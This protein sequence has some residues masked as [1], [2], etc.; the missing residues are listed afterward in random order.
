M[1]SGLQ[2]NFRAVLKEKGLRKGGTADNTGKHEIGISNNLKFPL[3]EFDVSVNQIRFV[4]HLE[5]SFIDS[6]R[7]YVT[8]LR[9]HSHR[10]IFVID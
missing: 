1:P 9:E 10:L 6:L 4:I 8:Y 3:V 2:Q 5:T 7:A